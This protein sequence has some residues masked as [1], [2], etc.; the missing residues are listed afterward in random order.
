MS[1]KQAAKPA[2]ALNLAPPQ[3]EDD[4]LYV[5]DTT[6]QPDASNGTIVVS[7][8]RTHDI[9]DANG[10][11]TVYTFRYREPLRMPFEHA[12]KFLRHEGFERTDAD[13][14]P[15]TWVRAPKRPDEME[16]GAQFVLGDDQVVAFLHELTDE[17]LRRRI[18]TLPGGERYTKLPREAII[19]AYEMLARKMREA[20]TVDEG[21]EREANDEYE[22]PLMASEAA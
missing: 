16:A 19:D 20:N 3:D 22:P 12:A 2:G 9:V 21:A 1:I 14:N 17:A 5:I 13:G 11:V 7:G 18:A 4:V 15:L 8:A 6:A 10:K